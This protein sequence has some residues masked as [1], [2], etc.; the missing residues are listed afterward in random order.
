M[1][2]FSD[3][4]N[5]TDNNV[6]VENNAQT[7]NNSEESAA[8][9]DEYEDG[10]SGNAM[11]SDGSVEGKSG[12][13]MESDTFKESDSGD[14]LEPNDSKEGVA[15]Q[16]DSGDGEECGPVGQTCMARKVWLHKQC[17]KL[18]VQMGG[19]VVPDG[20]DEEYEDLSL[21]LQGMEEDGPDWALQGAKME[22]V[23]EVFGPARKV[24]SPRLAFHLPALQLLMYN[25]SLG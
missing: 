4:L 24:P 20:V 9:Q 8:E 23:E 16:D 3:L 15:E 10:T 21:E 25:A 7:V 19:A 17:A 6:G 5:V 22:L 12:L 18:Y 2:G 14:S 13:A 11:E 1:P